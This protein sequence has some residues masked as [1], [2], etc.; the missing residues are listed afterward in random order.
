VLE[1]VLRALKALR[2]GLADRLLDDAGPGEP[3]E[4]ARLGEDHVAEH[5][6]RR[7]DAARG[8]VREDREIRQPRRGKLG[9]R[10][11]RLRHLH[12]REDALLHPGAA[13]RGE[14]DDA[15]APLEAPLDG[16]GDLLADHRAHAAP[17]EPELEDGEHRGKRL[18]GRLPADDALLRLRL[19][20]RVGHARGIGLCVAEGQRVARD[21]VGVD[22]DERALVGD[23]GDPVGGRDAEVI[24][25]LRTDGEVPL[26]LLVVDDLAAVAALRPEAFGDLDLL[27]RRAAL[28]RLVP[29][30]PGH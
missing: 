3:D 21:E 17:E 10:G 30:E 29:R 16:A 20:L 11:A 28:G 13:G 12:E 4:G 14:D 8:R 22:L 27:L 2:E 7:R 26:E 23:E 9:Q 15:G 1:K 6:E 18:D 19:P 24:L 25:A 5:C